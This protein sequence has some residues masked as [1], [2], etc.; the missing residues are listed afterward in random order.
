MTLVQKL[1]LVL[2]VLVIAQ[3]VFSQTPECGIDFEKEKSFKL[4]SRT[5]W[6]SQGEEMNTFVI[7]I[8]PSQFEM[9]YLMEIVS[10]FR[11]SCRMNGNITIEFDDKSAKYPEDWKPNPY[12]RLQKD[13]YWGFYWLSRKHSFDLLSYSDKQ[14]IY[15]VEFKEKGYCVTIEPP[16]E[17]PN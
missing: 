13:K 3:V 6:I 10:R 2:L 7:E 11:T 1:L 16:D 15:S 5:Q 17:N 9:N 12:R 8:K 14:N 4:F